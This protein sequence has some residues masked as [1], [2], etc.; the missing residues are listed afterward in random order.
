MVDNIKKYINETNFP[1]N[2]TEEISNAKLPLGTKLEGDKLVIEGYKKLKTISLNDHKLIKEVIIV[3]CPELTE[4]SLKNDKIAKLDITKIKTDDD[5]DTGDSDKTQKLKKIRIG[6]NPDLEEVSLKF[7][8]E[9]T[10]FTS[11]GNTKHDKI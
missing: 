1:K 5:T 11:R 10:E 6:D 2:I 3:N 8:P 4:I 9:L 7:C